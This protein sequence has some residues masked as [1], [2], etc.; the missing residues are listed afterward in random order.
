MATEEEFSY[1]SRRR[2]SWLK[3]DY[4]LCSTDKQTRLAVMCTISAVNIE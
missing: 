2:A 4:V 3:L 1:E